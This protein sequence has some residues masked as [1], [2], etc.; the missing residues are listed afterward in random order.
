MTGAILFYLGAFLIVWLW[1]WSWCLNRA[2][3]SCG[4]K[5]TLKLNGFP[6]CRSCWARLKPHLDLLME[7]VEYLRESGIPDEE[8][9]RFV[10]Q[11]GTTEQ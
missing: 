5:A 7:Q 8:I 2:C 9:N 10:Q 6:L 3:A 11:F 1:L 4:H